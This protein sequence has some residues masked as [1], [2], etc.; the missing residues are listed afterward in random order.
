MAWTASSISWPLLAFS[1]PVTHKTS[2]VKHLELRRWGECSL[3]QC[4]CPLLVK[5]HQKLTRDG[6]SDVHGILAEVQSDGRQQA[7]NGWKE[8]TRHLIY[9]PERAGV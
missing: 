4:L 7:G 9:R 8:T 3:G 2:A 1:W 5:F 6:F